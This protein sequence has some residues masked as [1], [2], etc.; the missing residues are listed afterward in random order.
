MSIDMS[1]FKALTAAHD[2]T[3]AFDMLFYRCFGFTVHKTSFAMEY[4]N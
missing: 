1:E 4:I 3:S 2:K